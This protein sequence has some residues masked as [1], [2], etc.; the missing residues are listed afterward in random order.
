ME[1]LTLPEELQLAAVDHLRRIQLV[2]QSMTLQ[3][4]AAERLE[5]LAELDRACDALCATVAWLLE[6]PEDGEPIPASRQNDRL[7]PCQ[8]EFSSHTG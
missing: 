1:R 2:V 7:V 6:E 5:W 3:M 8:W 4:A